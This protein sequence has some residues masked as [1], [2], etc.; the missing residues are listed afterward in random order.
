MLEEE[1]HLSVREAVERLERSFTQESESSSQ[2]SGHDPGYLRSTQSSNKKRISRPNSPLIEPV[3]KK[4]RM[5]NVHSQRKQPRLSSIMKHHDTHSNQINKSP[6]RRDSRL[7]HRRESRPPQRRESRAS[8]VF[9]H[10]SDTLA[11]NNKDDESLIQLDYLYAKYLQYEFLNFRLKKHLALVKQAT[12][13]ELDL[14]REALEEKKR[15]EMTALETSDVYKFLQQIEKIINQI[16]ARQAATDH[17]QPTATT[18]LKEEKREFLTL[19]Q[20]LDDFR[21]PVSSAHIGMEM[22]VEI[23][24]LIQEI[25]NQ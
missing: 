15:Q 20:S 12:E 4:P 17:E 8:S 22:L 19:L 14:A 23:R 10:H 3:L 9:S 11:S 16:E 25:L 7:L 24:S 18:V 21:I 2:K 13:R 6:A 1:N 5:S